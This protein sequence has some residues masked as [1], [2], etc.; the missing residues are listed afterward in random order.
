[1]LA[2]LSKN[3]QGVAERERF[4]MVRNLDHR[5]DAALLILD[6]Q[7]CKELRDII[8]MQ[9]SDNVKARIRDNNLSNKNVRS[10]DGEEVH[11]QIETY[12]YLFEE[13]DQKRKEA[14]TTVVQ[15]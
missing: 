1:M 6:R 7:L 5:I 14:I 12:H 11:S 2:D 13:L 3:D 10:N 9:L 8:E 4:K 15:Q